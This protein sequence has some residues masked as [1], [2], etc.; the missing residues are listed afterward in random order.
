MPHYTLGPYNE[1]ATVNITCVS[2]GGKY[3]LLIHYRKMK[4]E[5]LRVD[6]TTTFATYVN[7]DKI[8]KV[9]KLR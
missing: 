8:I 5:A 9:V 2:M 3:S 1:G 7:V 4:K 6:Y